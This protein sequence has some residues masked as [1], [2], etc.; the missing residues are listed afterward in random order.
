MNRGFGKYQA[1]EETENAPLLERLK[2]VEDLLTGIQAQLARLL[3]LYLSGEFSK[4]ILTDRKERLESTIDALE[5][6]R[7]NLAAHLMTHTLT[8]DQIRDLQGFLSEITQ[9]L[10]IADADFRTHRRVIEALDVRATLTIEDGERVIHAHCIVDRQEIRTVSRTARSRSVQLLG[11]A[12]GEQPGKL[13]DQ[14][15]ASYN[16]PGPAR[17]C[18]RNARGSR[19]RGS[20]GFQEGEP[21][22]KREITKA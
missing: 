10:Q 3:D 1:E 17:R 19:V 8:E 13:D 18:L 6:E 7:A 5:R 2:V 9:G 15:M 11:I 20:Y 14:G 16:R 21:R 4:Q 12:L 22:P